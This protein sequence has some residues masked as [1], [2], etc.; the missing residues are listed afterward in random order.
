MLKKR[1][2]NPPAENTWLEY[3]YNVADG[4]RQAAMQEDLAGR[5]TRGAVPN[6]CPTPVPPLNPSMLPGVLEA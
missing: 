2:A 4:I 5:A 3:V 1:P 6:P